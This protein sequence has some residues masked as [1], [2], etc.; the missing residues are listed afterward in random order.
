MKI[1]TVDAFAI[2]PY[3]GNPAAVTIV[4][5]FPDDAIC[6]KIAAEMNL[7]E[8]AFAKKLSE[9]HYHL[10]WFTPKVEVK[11]CGHATLATAHILYNEKIVDEK[12]TIHFTTLSGSLFVSKNSKGITLNFPLQKTGP[13]LD[14]PDVK[15]VFGQSFVTM[16]KAY[17]DLIVE[18]SDETA[19]RELNLNPELI[20]SLDCRGL[21]VTA[22]GTD[23]YD[24]VSRFFAPRVGV[25]EDPVTGS[26]HC[27]LADYWQKKLGKNKFLAYQASAR[28]GEIQVEV[29]ND[30]ALLTGR[31]IT[32]MA[33]EWLIHFS[34]TVTT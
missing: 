5:E 23:S 14:L 33:G 25:N 15:T 12:E 7:S 1:W 11:L 30:R 8:T 9:N 13:T 31:A 4:D 20:K 3:T 17:D 32:I 2:K 26:A 21:I 10:R 22:K 34:N 6:Q 28:G 16:E 24:F 18:L 29:K 27:K 19:V